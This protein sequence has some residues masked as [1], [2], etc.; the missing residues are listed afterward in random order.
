MAREDHI[1]GFYLRSVVKRL[2]E[3]HAIEQ[4]NG[5]GFTAVPVV[6]RLS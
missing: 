5:D 4:N 2:W 6:N 3:Q 1:L